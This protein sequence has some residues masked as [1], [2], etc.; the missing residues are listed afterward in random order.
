MSDVTKSEVPA[1][2]LNIIATEC[3][4]RSADND[5]LA[6]RICYSLQFINQFWWMAEQ[7]IEKKLKAIFL[8]RGFTIIQY[9]HDLNK[10]LGHCQYI[11]LTLTEEQIKFID[12]VNIR[13]NRYFED[14]L[15]LGDASLTENGRYKEL[16][17]LDNVI[18]VLE[19]IC[20][21][22]KP[23]GKNISQSINA[24][25]SRI[26]NFQNK[27]GE[28]TDREEIVLEKRVFFTCKMSP[29][30]RPEV[31]DWLTKDDNHINT[32]GKTMKIDKKSCIHEMIQNKKKGYHRKPVPAV[33]K[34]A[35]QF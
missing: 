11:G 22:L 17:A 34:T 33:V 3:F 28:N 19:D 6:A 24:N 16:D 35:N 5:Y 4:R 1:A 23:K 14:S 27:N 32:L 30:L 31:L 18:Q 10:I 8:Y 21:T 7:A 25:Q 20:E 26:F 12:D 29:Y 13:K 2:V 9:S 15:M